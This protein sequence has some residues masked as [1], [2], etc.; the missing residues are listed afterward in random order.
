MT[1]AHFHDHP[2]RRVSSRST[3]I[4]RLER[5][6]R[7]LVQLNKLLC[8]YRCEPKTYARFE[9]LSELKMRIQE[10]RR[11]NLEIISGILSEEEHQKVSLG[12][13]RRQLLEFNELQRRVEGYRNPI[14]FVG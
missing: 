5:N 10:L 13:I 6:N 7:D 8:C 3:S 1:T 4:L 11:S 2:D 9:E 12:R 14:R